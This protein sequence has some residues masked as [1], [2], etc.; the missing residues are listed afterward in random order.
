MREWL[1]G[2]W[3]K[4]WSGRTWA[5][6]VS[7]AVFMSLLSGLSYAAQG[8]KMV[9]AGKTDVAAVTN[10]V[11][12]ASMTTFLFASLFGALLVTREYSSGSISR[13]V[14]L[15]GGRDRLFLAKLVVAAAVGAL[16]GL[17]AV[18][19][20]TV[21]SWVML[22]GYGYSSEWTSET[23][24]IALGV[25]ACNVLAAPWGVFVGWIVRHQIGAVGAL[26]A[27]TLLVDPALKRLVPDE[28]KYLLTVAMSSV[29]RDGAADLLS[30]QTALLVIAGWLAAAGYAAH[31]LLHSRD[32]T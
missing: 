8:D 12:R 1:L 25:F 6:L 24:L 15:I 21:S 19:L 2:E 28:A 4:A 18:L 11:V 7:I 30:P 16:F 17:F 5:V 32:I 13:S 29:Y 3:T 9:S 14:L 10:D 22:A 31:K 20:A 26:M 23:W 27:L